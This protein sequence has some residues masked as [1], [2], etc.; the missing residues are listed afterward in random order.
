MT[1]ALIG[2]SWL[3]TKA[4]SKMLIRQQLEMLTSL[5]KEYLSIDIALVR[6]ER[7]L[8]DFLTRVSQWSLNDMKEIKPFQ[9]V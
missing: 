1:N 5:V 3:N 8:A 9:L 6:F 7:N 2:K 4:M